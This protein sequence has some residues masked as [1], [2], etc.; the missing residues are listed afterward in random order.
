MKRTEILLLC[1]F[2]LLACAC[3]G[4]KEPTTPEKPSTISI[5]PTNLS[6]E[7]SDSPKEL[8]V[9]SNAS[10]RVSR[11]VA[12]INVDVNSGSDNGSV[13]VSVT[14]ND[15]EARSGKVT[16]YV[17]GLENTVVEVSQKGISAKDIVPI[18]S[19]ADGKKRAS[20]SYQLLVYSFCDGDGD[21]IGDFKGITSKMD[22]F[23]KLG[24]TGL[25][26]SPIHPAHSYHAYDV[27]DYYSV[28]PQYGTEADFKAMVDAAHDHG[29]EI[30]LDYVLNHTSRSH[31][32]FQSAISD[33]SGP[34]RDYYFISTDP[35]G[36]IQSGKFPA[37]TTANYNEAEWKDTESGTGSSARYKFVLD[38]SAKTVTVTVSEETPYEGTSS[39]GWNIWYGDSKCKYFRP[40]GGNMY[41]IVFDFASD[42]GFLIRSASDWGENDSNKYGAPSG[43]SSVIKPGTAF[44]LQQAGGNITF[45]LS[46]KYMCCFSDWMPDVNYGSAATCENS[47]PFKD[48][49]ASADKW[50]KMGVDGLRLDAVKH[51]YG[52]IANWSNSSN[53]AFLRKWY[54]HCNATYKSQGHTGDMFMVGEVFNEF[55]DSGAPYNVYLQGLPSVFD[56]SFWWRVSDALNGNITGSSFV[57]NLIAQENYFSNGIASL[58]L[59]NHDEDRTG[60]ILGKSAAKEKQAAA[61]LLTSP[62][63]PFIYQ[64]EELG[65]YGGKGGGDEYVRTP[66]NW[67]G[68]S[69]AG[70]LLGDKVIS[71]L[72][73]AACSVKAQDA[74]KSSVLEVYKSFSAVRNTYDA[75]A[76][77]TM[78]SCSGITDS[79]L[80]AWYMTDSA[81]HKMLVIHNVTDSA[82]TFEATDDTSKPVALLGTCSQKGTKLILGANSSVVFKLY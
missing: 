31:P 81:G 56:F 22:Y 3:G 23:D 8:K 4:G 7:A 73:G 45:S 71:A 21:G 67:D 62:G 32:W 9:S 61:L 24:V 69:W 20:T 48:M 51:I 19:E 36:D 52:G 34:Y 77:G 28:N 49:A 57:N 35:Y 29:I 72:K 70:K 78:S 82:R 16:F 37:L 44:A 46:D 42:W 2:S 10:W 80:A 5:S 68:G 39:A 26:L 58:K 13:M 43:G 33:P 12:W 74:D 25:W 66:M 75:L 14:D 65:Y 47:A 38:A 40:D 6:F 50:I 17:T 63:K 60:E 27:E 30:Y 64:G 76:S 15:G 18:S 55:N 54:D 11:D 59:S 79:A 41:S 53:Q 1:L